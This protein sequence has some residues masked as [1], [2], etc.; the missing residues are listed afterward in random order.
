MVSE[1]HKKSPMSATSPL[2][3]KKEEDRHEGDLSPIKKQKQVRVTTMTFSNESVSTVKPTD[4]QK[5]NTGFALGSVSNNLAKKKLV[6][7]LI[8]VEDQETAL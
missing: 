6:G 7:S 1:E 3:K 2:N 5:Q 8:Q 4:L